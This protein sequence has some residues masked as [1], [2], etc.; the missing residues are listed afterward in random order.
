MMLKKECS[1]LFRSDSFGRDTWA[2][3]V[4]LLQMLAI[5]PPHAL[6]FLPC[7]RMFFSS[8]RYLLALPQGLFS[9]MQV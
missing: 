7:F 4:V 3:A 2:R 6:V 1:G 5:V 9:G 8:G